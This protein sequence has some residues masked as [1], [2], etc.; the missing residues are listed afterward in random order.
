MQTVAALREELLA[1]V[2]Q[3]LAIAKELAHTMQIN[4]RADADALLLAARDAR[5]ADARRL[6]HRILNT[7]QLL[8][9]PVLADLSL[10]VE[11][12]LAREDGPAREQLLPEYLSA[13]SELNGVLDRVSRTF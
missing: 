4:H 8:G 5:W 7:A 6:A 13:V 10:R 1:K 3:D 9:C 11:E 12:T 2:G